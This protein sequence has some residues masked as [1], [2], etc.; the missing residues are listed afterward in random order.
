MKK[1]SWEKFL[2]VRSISRFVFLSSI[3]LMFITLMC[4]SFNMK[5]LEL[6]GF[7]AVIFAAIFLIL[8]W[9]APGIFFILKS[10]QLAY[11]WILGTSIGNLD[12]PWEK[13]SKWRKFFLYLRSFL[14]LA[15]LTFGAILFIGRMIQ[16][17]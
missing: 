16:I 15:F 14:L 7:G 17:W 5:L 3:I 2:R 1:D 4:F 6:F 12:K 9:I 10:P 8:S 11:A 13:L